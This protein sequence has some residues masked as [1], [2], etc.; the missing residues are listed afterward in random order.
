M[1]RLPVSGGSAPLTL[2][3]APIGS[4]VHVPR[5][6]DDGE[7]FW[8]WCPVVGHR[9][10]RLIVSVPEPSGLI[11]QPISIGIIEKF[12][13]SAAPIVRHGGSADS[14]PAPKPAP[15]RRSSAPPDEPAPKRPK[16]A[17]RASIPKVIL[18]LRHPS[19]SLSSTPFGV[20]GPCGGDTPNDAYALADATAEPSKLWP[21]GSSWMPSTANWGTRNP[22]A[23]G[24]GKC[25]WRPAGCR[26]CIAASIAYAQTSPPPPFLAPGVVSIPARGIDEDAEKSGPLDER[27]E[28]LA[29]LLKSVEVTREG[30]SDPYGSGVVARRHL[31]PGEVLIDP[32]V[33]YVPRPSEYAQ[34]H[35]PQYN[36]LELGTAGYFRLR[37][38]AYAHCSLT[39]FVNEA[40]HLGCV[41][42]PAANVKY[43]VV[44]PR[45]GGIA[46]GLEVLVPINARDELLCHYDQKL[47]H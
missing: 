41:D 1:S 16:P 4:E 31:R 44:R 18:K 12:R 37:E 22:N 46:L 38:P 47:K 40:Q 21:S 5:Q 24:C 36:A 27:K 23:Y 29:E 15:D 28:K 25:R 42:S 17:H 33:V 35:L 45:G 9:D 13:C 11:N 32:S 19:F 6:H 20:Q 7:R 43:K 2:Q 30:Q 10:G 8:T 14:A 34:A 26:G 3:A 39:F